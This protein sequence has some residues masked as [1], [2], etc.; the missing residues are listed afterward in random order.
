MKGSVSRTA[1]QRQT[2]TAGA[3]HKYRAQLDRQPQRLTNINSCKR[4][5]NCRRRSIEI[6]RRRHSPLS[7]AQSAA[8]GDAPIDGFFPRTRVPLRQRVRVGIE[9][10][11]FLFSKFDSG[12]LA[13][14][15]PP[16]G[17]SNHPRCSL[18][19]PYDVNFSTRTRHRLC[20]RTHN[21][22]VVASTACA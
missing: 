14:N 8:I 18:A 19:Q 9:S 10:R 21:E 13:H 4:G 6:G 22:S 11:K 1:I 15:C 12:R 16:S 17:Y 5:L 7:G 20:A 2:P 3:T